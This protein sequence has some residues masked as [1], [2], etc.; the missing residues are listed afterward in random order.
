VN[1]WVT[2]LTAGND[3]AALL[4]AGNKPVGHFKQ[5]A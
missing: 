4:P 5:K 2:K 3:F 1:Q